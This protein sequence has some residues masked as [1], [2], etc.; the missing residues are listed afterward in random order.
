[1]TKCW[2]IDTSLSKQRARWR[3]RI[4]K[5]NIKNNFSIVLAYLARSFCYFGPCRHI[6][7]SNSAVI[8]VMK[9]DVNY[10]NFLSHT[11][12]FLVFSN[13]LF[14]ISPSARTYCVKRTRGKFSVL[15]R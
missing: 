2:N 15:S 13:S 9:F 11:E 6:D 10:A 8:I 4:E 14:D 5:R 7:D 12:Y 1:M 3:I